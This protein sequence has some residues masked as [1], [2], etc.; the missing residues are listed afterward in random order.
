MKMSG[1]ITFHHYLCLLIY[2]MVF[3]GCQDVSR[4]AEVSPEIRDIPVLC[5]QGGMPNLFVSENEQLYLTWIEYLN[6]STDAL[7]YSE[8]ENAR[9]SSPRTIATG[10]DWF[11]NWADFPSLAVYRDNHNFIAAH[12]LQKSAGGTYDYDVRIAITQDNGRHWHHKFIPHR[13]SIPTEHGFVSLVPLSGF[14]M[15]AVWLDGRNMKSGDGSHDHAHAGP[16]TLRSTIFD[17]E[18]ALEQEIELDDRVCECCQTDAT[19]TRQGLIVVYRD[20]D[21]NEVR[22]ISVVRKVRGQWTVPQSIYHDNWKI[23]GC[24]VNGPAVAAWGDTVAVAWYSAPN[25][26]AQVKVAFSFNAGADFNPPVRIDQGTP[27]GRVDVVML[28]SNEAL[29]TWME[30]TGQGAQIMA[31]QIDLQGRISE[32]LIIAQTSASRESGFPIVE[33]AG[34]QI[35]FAWTETDSVSVVKTAVIPLPD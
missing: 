20:R 25:D 32:S 2:I 11:V 27:A 21:E 28:S 22:D 19:L 3:C 4:S 14:K 8:L 23:A 9:W 10:T 1:H 6:D 33:K 35:F 34:R 7:Y 30:N 24:P 13:D 5:V 31:R 16:M 12:W 18:G 26:S 15:F 29:V 17:T